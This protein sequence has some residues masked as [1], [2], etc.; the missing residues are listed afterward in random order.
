MNKHL[1]SGFLGTVN[2]TK[3]TTLSSVL[4]A[5]RTCYRNRTCANAGGR[6]QKSIIESVLRL[7]MACTS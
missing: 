7:S 3:L 2:F 1:L 6:S 4:T 5:A